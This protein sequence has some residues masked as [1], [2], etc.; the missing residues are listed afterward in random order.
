MQCFF[1]SH[2]IFKINLLQNGSTKDPVSCIIFAQKGKA[3]HNF[4]MNDEGCTMMLCIV[5]GFRWRG[6]LQVI[7]PAAMYVHS[8]GKHSQKVLFPSPLEQTEQMLCFSYHRKIDFDYIS[9]SIE[10][11]FVWVLVKWWLYGDCDDGHFFMGVKQSR[12]Y[13]KIALWNIKLSY[14]CTSNWYL[15]QVLKYWDFVLGEIYMSPTIR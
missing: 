15:R 7:I 8:A 14:E 12:K 9:M 6:C 13:S 5:P 4:V 2:W 10:G 3:N 1:L 11:L